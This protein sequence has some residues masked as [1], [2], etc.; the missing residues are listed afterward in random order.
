[1]LKFEVSLRGGDGKID[2]DK[3][4]KVH[5][6]S[7]ATIAQRT[8]DGA[9][10]SPLV[11]VCQQYM[12]PHVGEYT[13]RDICRQAAIRNALVS[14]KLA[15]VCA[16]H[17]IYCM[18]D[19]TGDAES[20][21]IDTRG[22]AINGP[23]MFYFHNAHDEPETAK[24]NMRIAQLNNVTPTATGGAGH[25]RSQYP[26]PV[27]IPTSN[28]FANRRLARSD[29]NNQESSEMIVHAGGAM[30]VLSNDSGQWVDTTELEK[31]LDTMKKQIAEEFER[32]RNEAL[33][34]K[35][36]IDALAPGGSVGPTDL[37][38]LS[39]KLRKNIKK[40]AQKMDE[41]LDWMRR[42]FAEVRAK[43]NPHEVYVPRREDGRARKHGTLAKAAGFGDSDDDD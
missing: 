35:A 40:V 42:T 1:M 29:H 26:P 15:D 22:A 30:P 2:M 39:K 27:T 16:F 13:D 34:Q 8:L 28:V 41:E 33:A 9:D 24:A 11:L 14:G 43:R 23:A 32:L 12:T 37:K 21:V 38:E 3:V 20:E 6:E 7:D 25:S 10:I 31:F 17:Q 19:R 18:G 4:R 5:K 36:Q